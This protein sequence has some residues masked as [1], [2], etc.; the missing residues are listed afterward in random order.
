MTC[1]L[2]VH[3]VQRL[4]STMGSLYFLNFFDTTTVVYLTKSGLLAS[5]LCDESAVL[6]PS[7]V[8]SSVYATLQLH[9]TCVCVLNTTVAS[10]HSF[11]TPVTLCGLLMRWTS[12]SALDVFDKLVVDIY[13][14]RF[15]QWNVTY[16][17]EICLQ[18]L[19]H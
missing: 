4:V 15:V 11:M 16:V 10:D 19:Y 14:V 17:C 8:E 3:R 13:D 7:S 1:G 12:A 18:G 9:R 5:D 2:P 6:C